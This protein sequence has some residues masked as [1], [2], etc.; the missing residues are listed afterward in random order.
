MTNK[1][2]FEE[3]LKKQGYVEKNAYHYPDNF[4]PVIDS[5]F[6]RHFGSY[7]FHVYVRSTDRRIERKKEM[8]PILKDGT[9]LLYLYQIQMNTINPSAL[10][11]PSQPMLMI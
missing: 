3:E 10:I 1:E 8:K 6:E 11:F 5:Y 9:F 2:K 7:E 4:D